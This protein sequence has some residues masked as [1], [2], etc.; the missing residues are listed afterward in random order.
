MESTVLS[1]EK[2]QTVVTAGNDQ[3]GWSEYMHATGRDLDKL[4]REQAAYGRT[5]ADQHAAVQVAIGDAKCDVVAAVNE[6]N[7]QVLAGQHRSEIAAQVGFAGSADRI[8]ALDKS[9]TSQVA[10]GTEVTRDAQAKIEDSLGNV[11]SEQ[12]AQAKALAVRFGELESSLLRETGKCGS[13]LQLQIEQRFGELRLELCE[14]HCEIKALVTYESA[15]TRQQMAND[16]MRD[17]EIRNARLEALLDNAELRD[18]PKR[19]RA[20]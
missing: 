8:A 14:K 5:D 15:T 1:P 4:V 17:L 7:G 20:D 12:A 3:I 9:I 10:H 2:G 16:R 6:S 13:G 18:P 11:R 19:R